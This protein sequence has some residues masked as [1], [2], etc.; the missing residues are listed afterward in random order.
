M[1]R[2]N[3]VRRGRA[4]WPFELRERPGAFTSVVVRTCLAVV[5]EIA[6]SLR[7]RPADPPGTLLCVS[8]PVTIAADGASLQLWRGKNC[9][10]GRV[11]WRQ[12][13]SDPSSLHS[14]GVQPR[15]GCDTSC[16]GPSCWSCSLGGRVLHGTYCLSDGSR[17][18]TSPPR[19]PL[20][21][22]RPVV[23]EAF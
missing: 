12:C 17:S 3:A 5:S 18:L 15:F 11:R 16:A 23:Q 13:R 19:G 9:G 1:C 14:I 8:P 2:V 21:L 10:S 6:P 7:V 4:E 22:R 20:A